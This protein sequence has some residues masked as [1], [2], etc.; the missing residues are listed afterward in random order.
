MPAVA[1]YS[2]TFDLSICSAYKYVH[3]K[4][5]IYSMVLADHPLTFPTNSSLLL[6]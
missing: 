6:H 1:L 4:L 2:E 3:A 5:V